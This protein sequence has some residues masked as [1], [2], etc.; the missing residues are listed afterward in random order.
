[1]CVFLI[2]LFTYYYHLSSLIYWSLVYCYVV[3]CYFI[4]LLVG[5]YVCLFC[6]WIYCGCMV[7]IFICCYC[8][9]WWTGS[10]WFYFYT[11]S[12]AS[13]NPN[14]VPYPT[15]PTDP[16]SPQ[17]DTGKYPHPHHLYLPHLLPS[18]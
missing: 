18:T 4:W 7:C 2:L 10:I 15:Y 12:S 13:D 17:T 14:S 11:D 5:Y 3:Y 16:K 9:C 8:I 6:A 1:M